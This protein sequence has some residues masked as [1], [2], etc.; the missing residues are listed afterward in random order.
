MYL[1]QELAIP[2]GGGSEWTEL[3]TYPPLRWLRNII[4]GL[5]QKELI[6]FTEF[7]VSIS[8]GSFIFLLL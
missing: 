7:R 3:Q 6:A 1:K 8:N 2:P 4:I 5:H